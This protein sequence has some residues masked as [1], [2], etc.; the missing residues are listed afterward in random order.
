MKNSRSSSE[1]LL[2]K[3]TGHGLEL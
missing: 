3:T 2:A 1:S